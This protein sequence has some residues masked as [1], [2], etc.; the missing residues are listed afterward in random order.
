MLIHIYEIINIF[1]ASMPYYAQIKKFKETKNSEGYSTL[2]SF[3]ILTSS[4]LKIFFWF[5]KYYHW[6]LLMQAILI[7]A[8]HVWLVYEAVKYKNINQYKL[9]EPQNKEE[10]IEVILNVS[11]K[12][13]DESILF[14]FFAW[15]QIQLYAIFLV[16]YCFLLMG[17]CEI[18]G[19]ENSFFIETLGLI[20]TFIEGSMAIPQVLEINRTKNV[21]NISFVMIMCWFLG[22]FLK[23]YY[24]IVSGSPFQFMLIGIIQ[25]VLN[26]IIVYQYLIYSG[27]SDK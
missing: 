2:V 22:D 13:K 4:I 27:K 3:F 19:F 17:L 9:E 15:N 7:S 1:S 20:N 10:E 14:N 5:G 26:C 18:F 11:T 12:T 25:I 24:F 6:S 16:I 23:T 8:T 21:Q